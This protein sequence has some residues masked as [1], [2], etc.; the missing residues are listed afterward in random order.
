MICYQGAHYIAFFR[1]LLIK[2]DYLACDPT[3]VSQD[4]KTME[5]EITKQ[6]EWTY[7]DDAMIESKGTW[8]D[9]VQHCT[10]NRVYPT[11]LIFEKLDPNER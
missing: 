5:S 2:L 1:R 7:F 3:T 10:E 6:T 4:L 11:V 9:I 8:F